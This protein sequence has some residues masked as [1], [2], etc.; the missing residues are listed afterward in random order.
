MQPATGAP[1]DTGFAVDARVES[2]SA[3]KEI[4]ERSAPT[5]AIVYHA[6]KKVIAKLGY[7]VGFLIVV[8]GRQQLFTENTLTVILPLLRRRDR[9]TMR[10]VGRLWAVVLAANLVGAG[11][12]AAVAART[13]AFE[14]AVRDTFL[15][16]GHEAMAAATA[17]T[18]LRGIYAGW[19]IALM[20]WL[21][22]FAETARVWV[23]VIITYIVG[24]GHFSH[25]IA[26]SVETLYLVA[27][28]DRSLWEYLAGY[29]APS[30][31]GNVIGGVS[32][33]A[34]IAHAQFVAGPSASEA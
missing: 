14:P 31:V 15:A 17:T 27:A 23:I 20:V 26:G 24:V 9:V 7:T 11:M 22:P 1:D 21:L 18:L 16:I 3:K 13:T 5:G 30:F 25:V 2:G 28:G 8:L 34:A 33:V 32:L 19:L 6:V 29:L 12:F 10:N 4:H